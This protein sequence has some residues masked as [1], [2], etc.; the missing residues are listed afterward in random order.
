MN[1]KD[2]IL[3]IIGNDTKYLRLVDEIIFLEGQLEELKKYPFLS[4]N[5]KNKAQQKPTAAAKLYKDLLQQY[6]NCLKTLYKATGQNE[7]DEESPLRKWV[8]KHVNSE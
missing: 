5:P 4:V 1:R 2:E 6:N 8:K 3:K 7:N